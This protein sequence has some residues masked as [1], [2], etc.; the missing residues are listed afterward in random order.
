MKNFWRMND[1]SIF[2]VPYAYVDHSSYQADQLFRQNNVNMKFKGEMVREDSKYCIVFCKVLKRDVEKFE[3]ALEKLNDKMLLLGY[4][5]YQD[6]CG[7][8]QAIIDK[9][10]MRGSKNET[11]CTS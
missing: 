11:I 8:I 2:R 9:V 7:E 1:F 10:T 3:N 5:D 4:R 6:A